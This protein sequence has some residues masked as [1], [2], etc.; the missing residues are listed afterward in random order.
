[1]AWATGKSSVSARPSCS[2]SQ[3]TAQMMTPT[4]RPPKSM[5]TYQTI[6]LDIT[7]YTLNLQIFSKT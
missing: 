1:M 6:C 4:D 2:R 3:R 5:P 7:F